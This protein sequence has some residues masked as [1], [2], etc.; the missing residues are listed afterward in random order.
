MGVMKAYSNVVYTE[1]EAINAVWVLS[2][3]S[4]IFFMQLGFALLECG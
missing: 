4:M 2:C 1:D 3:A